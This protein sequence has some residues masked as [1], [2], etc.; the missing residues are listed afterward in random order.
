MDDNENNVEKLEEEVQFD[1]ENN[2]VKLGEE[3]QDEEAQK[4]KSINKV[5]L[6]IYICLVLVPMVTLITMICSSIIDYSRW[7][8][9]T[10]TNIQKQNKANFP[11]LTFCPTPNG[12]KSDILKVNLQL[13]N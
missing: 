11:S 13:Q 12:Y 10:E 1:N 5:K 2:F 4:I 9:Y 6:A 7:P 3:T 8:I